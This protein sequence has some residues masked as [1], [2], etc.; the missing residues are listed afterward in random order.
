MKRR[1]LP[2]SMLMFLSVLSLSAEVKVSYVPLKSETITSQ[3]IKEYPQPTEFSGKSQLMTIYPDIKFQRLS[4]IGGCFNEMGGEALEALSK[5][6][7]AEILDALF[8]VDSGSAFTFCRMP[9]GASDFAFDAY[10]FA[11]VAGDYEMKH[12]SLKRDEKHLLPYIKK[13]LNINP[14]MRIFASPWSPPAWMK[15][16]G[17]MDRG[18]EFRDKNGIIDDPKIYKAYALYF[19]KFVEEYRKRGVE[20]ERILVQ[21]EQDSRAKFPSCRF[22]IDQMS[23]FVRDYMRPRFETEGLKTEIWAGTFRTAEEADGLRFAA[24]REYQSH[25]DGMGIQYTRPQ[26]IQD[27]TTLAPDLKLMHTEG[28]CFNGKNNDEQAQTRFEEVANYINGGSENFCYWNIILNET[29]K[30]GWQWRQNAMITIDRTAKSV[31]YNPDY[32]AMKLLSAFI[33]PGAVRVASFSR[34]GLISSEYGGS[35]YLV[36]QNDGD[37]AIHYACNIAGREV[38]FEIPAQSLCGVKINY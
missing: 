11:D 5:A 12:F 7:Q 3:P 1:I 17:F 15:Q 22:L 38:K 25:F 32:A 36:L 9:I 23:M 20:V 30:S 37:K 26:Y 10:S 8:N 27:I 34:S 14:E 31:T 21:N 29:G 4:G 6:Q 35:Y 33:K 13:A 18:F 24:S 2:L 19:A 28:A 16:S